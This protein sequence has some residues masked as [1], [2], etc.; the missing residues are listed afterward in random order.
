MW[1]RV[2]D[3]DRMFGAMNLLHSRMNRLFTDYDRSYGTD[4]GWR[5]SGGTPK[6]NMY[7]LGD[8]LQVVAEL[9]GVAK[10]DLNVRIQGNYLELSGSRKSD[11][12]EGYK[13]HRIERGSSTFTRSFTLPVD[14]DSERVEA[15]LKDGVLKMILPKVEAAKPKQITVS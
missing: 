15:V 10:E 12:P 14:V 9:P 8:K 13:A 7:D 6:T 4:A 5:V 1:T 2:S 11:G 3:I